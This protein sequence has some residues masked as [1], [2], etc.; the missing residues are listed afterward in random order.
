MY[1]IY[2]FEVLITT[3]VIVV[4]TM[5]SHCESEAIYVYCIEKVSKFLHF[6]AVV[7]HRLII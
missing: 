6:F 7:Y 1:L 4:S 3:N 5:I 2:C